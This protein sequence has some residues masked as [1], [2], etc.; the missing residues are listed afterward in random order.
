M[1]LMVVIIVMI[2]VMTILVLVLTLLVVGLVTRVGVEKHGG[3]RSED[4]GL[5]SS[6]MSLMLCSVMSVIRSMLSRIS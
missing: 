1:I 4:D 3:G 2:M 5:I 6:G